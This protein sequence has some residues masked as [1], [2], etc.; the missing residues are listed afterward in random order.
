MLYFVLAKKRV[1]P[2]D[3][4]SSRTTTITTKAQKKECELFFG[5]EKE[6][7]SEIEATMC[8]CLCV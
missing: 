2:R 7:V 8:E 3:R 4:N 5:E 1:R 6:V